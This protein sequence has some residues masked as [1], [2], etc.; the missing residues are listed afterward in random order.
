MGFAI[1][2]NCNFSIWDWLQLSCGLQLSCEAHLLLLLSFN[3]KAHLLLL[4]VLYFNRKDMMCHES[5]ISFL[6]MYDNLKLKSDATF[7]FKF[8]FNFTTI[9]A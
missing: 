2:F 6:S 4:G 3:R 8:K 5:K 1:K 7:K 9:K